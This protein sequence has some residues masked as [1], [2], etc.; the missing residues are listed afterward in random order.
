MF[1]RLMRGIAKGAGWCSRRGF[2][3]CISS[4]SSLSSLS[5]LSSLC[6]LLSSLSLLSSSC[7]FSAISIDTS[8]MADNH[9]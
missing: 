6:L 5:L 8:G 2:S 4:S 1:P 3:S 7:P 9:L